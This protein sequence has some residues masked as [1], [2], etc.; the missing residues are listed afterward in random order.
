MGAYLVV[1]I[2]KETLRVIHAGIYSSPA[3]SLTGS[4]NGVYADIFG[5][6]LP[7]YE[8]GHRY[9]LETLRLMPGY[10]GWLYPFFKEELYRMDTNNRA[11]P[12][13]DEDETEDLERLIWNDEWWEAYTQAHWP[14]L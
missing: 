8:D 4:G 6:R 1:T 9:I 14:S 3:G 7:S 5:D 2:N 12:L 10:W 13:C 11:R